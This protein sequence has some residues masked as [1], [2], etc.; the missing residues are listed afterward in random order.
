MAKNRIEKQSGWVFRFHIS[1]CCPTA[2]HWLLVM[3]S[4]ISLDFQASVSR[5]HGPPDKLWPSMK[6]HSDESKQIEPLVNKYKCWLLGWKPNALKSTRGNGLSRYGHKT[7]AIAYW[8]KCVKAS[9]QTASGSGTS[10]QKVSKE[11]SPNR[12]A[13]LTSPWSQQ[14]QCF[15]PSWIASTGLK[16]AIW[17]RRP[18]HQHQWIAT[19]PSRIIFTGTKIRS[20]THPPIPFPTLWFAN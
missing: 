1:G 2:V 20:E 19:S 10:Q 11:Q 9:R 18:N 7:S 4:E 16:S 12:W 13:T 8:T 5:P 3:I 6:Q 17:N 15:I 14:S